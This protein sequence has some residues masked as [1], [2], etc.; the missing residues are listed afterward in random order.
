MQVRLNGK[1]VHLPDGMTVRDL[2]R[3]YELE[4]EPVAVERNGQIVDRRDFG[5]ERLQAGDVIELVRFVGGG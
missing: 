1:D 2:I 3:H 4:G 5:A